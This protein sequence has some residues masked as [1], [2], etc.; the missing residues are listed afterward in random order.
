MIIVPILVEL[1]K[2]VDRQISLFSGVDFTVDEANG[3]NGVYD[4]IISRS[5]RQFAVNAPILMPVK[6]KN[7]D[8][9]RDLSQ[10]LAEI[11]AAQ[12]FNVREGNASHPVYGVVTI[13]SNCA[14]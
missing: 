12:L 10:C 2:L 13:G 4:Y 1:R 9:K 8:M 5:P 3:L 7:E 14:F 6:A 11:V